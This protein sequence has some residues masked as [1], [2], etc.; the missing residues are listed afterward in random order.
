MTTYTARE[1]ATRSRL[2][3]MET[4]P[5]FHLVDGTFAAALLEILMRLERLEYEVY[6]RTPGQ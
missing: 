4:K 2:K 3:E 1:A 5:G 6:G